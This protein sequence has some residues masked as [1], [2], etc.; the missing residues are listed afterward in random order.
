MYPGNADGTSVACPRDL[1]N[2]GPSTRG[3]SEEVCCKGRAEKLLQVPH[4]DLHMQLT[5][6][7]ARR[8]APCPCIA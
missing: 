7:E 3:T 8:T 5:I 1:T 6:L 4:M 2:L